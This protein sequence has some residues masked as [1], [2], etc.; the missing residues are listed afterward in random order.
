[1][2]TIKVLMKVITI[3][4]KIKKLKASIKIKTKL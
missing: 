3:I 4:T 1:M 2:I